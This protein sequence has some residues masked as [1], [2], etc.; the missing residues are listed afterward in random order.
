MGKPIGVIVAV[1]VVLLTSCGRKGDPLPPIIEV[2][3]TTTD[4]VVRQETSESVLLWSYPQLTRAGNTLTDLARI[5]VWRLEVPPGQEQVGQGAAGEEM[6]RQLMLNRGRLVARLEGPSLKEAT[7]GSQLV[8]RDPLPTQVESTVPSAL[9]YGVRSRRRDG[10]TSALSNIVSLLPKPIP[11]VVK[12]VT[13]KAGVEGVALSWSALP[14]ARYL[15][16]RRSADVDAWQ[17]LT[18][19]PLDNPELLDGGARQ[20]M[21]WVYR[22]RAVVD[23]VWGPPSKE[24]VAK[25]P[26]IYPPATPT[27]LICLPEPGTVR[28]RWDLASEPGMRYMVF[29]RSPRGWL[30][31]ATN[32]EAAELVDAK[33]PA[34][35]LEY[36]V[37]AVDGAGN[38]SQDVRCKVRL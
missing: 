9:W 17:M 11:G 15:V 28:L 26:D 37:K 36:A 6:R 8:H 1:L 35:E 12:G 3:E 27:G 18:A 31:L 5:E 23:G 25:H 33:A 29:R 20:A 34:G 7:R 16:E 30:Q 4:L 24:T 13:A 32:L 2:P 14:L 19:A 22:V 21:T 10:T 38:Q